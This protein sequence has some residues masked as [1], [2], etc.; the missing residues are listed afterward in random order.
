MSGNRP[1]IRPA[2]RPGF[3]THDPRFAG[4]VGSDPA[5]EIL[6]ETDA[7]EGPTWCAEDSCLYVTSVPR[8]AAAGGPRV[9]VR[10][11]HLDVDGRPDSAVETVVTGL[12]G[13]NGMTL[14]RHGRLVVCQQGDATAPAAI[15]LVDRTTGTVETLVDSWHGVPFNSPNDVAVR[16]DGTVWFT[17]PSY[18]HLQ[19]FRP[20]PAS[21]DHV[22][23]VDPATG[24]VDVVADGFDK[25]NGLV[26]SPDERVLYV[27]DS[28]ANQA[29]GSWHPGRP[30]SVSAFTAAGGRR[31]GARWL[32]AVLP[33]A[34][35]DGL[36]VDRSGRLYVCSAA[37]VEVHHPD[38]GL[39][40]EIVVPG[41][42]NAV[43]GGPGHRHLF[44]TADTSVW[45]ARLAAA[46]VQRPTVAAPEPVAA[47]V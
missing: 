28:G 7:H 12:P 18:G 23:R 31:L 15:V 24:A 3:V 38:G 4:V 37:G 47:R 14:D 42:V 19:G 27:A 9:D 13:A 46:G 11:L 33:R 20:A 10:R 44:V 35:P 30:H 39:L 29:A 34:H 40:G 41:A 25:P 45:V 16:R 2:M 26:F 5:L 22:Y 17:D 36:A 32:V 21:G 6:V 43:F 1:A 8:T